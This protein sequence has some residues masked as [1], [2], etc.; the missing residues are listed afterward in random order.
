MVSPNLLMKPL[1]E[2]LFMEDV[3]T[4]PINFYSSEY[5]KICWKSQKD[6]VGMEQNFYR[7]LFVEEINF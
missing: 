1:T 4:F 5:T 2:F 3:M 7:P 6:A